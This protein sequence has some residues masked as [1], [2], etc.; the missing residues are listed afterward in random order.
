MAFNA[1]VCE[2][3]GSSHGQ[4]VAP[5]IFS[6]HVA[7]AILLKSEI[8]T[9]TSDAGKGL[10]QYHTDDL[11]VSCPGVSL[12]SAILSYQYMAANLVACEL[13]A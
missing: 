13:N 3:A 1:Y 2:L 12:A 8:Q 5:A 10:L 7:F 6:P 4:G 11:V 9:P